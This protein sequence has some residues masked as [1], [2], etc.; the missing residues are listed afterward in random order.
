MKDDRRAGRDNYGS[1][2]L[3]TFGRSPTGRE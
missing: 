2:P 1:R 3:A